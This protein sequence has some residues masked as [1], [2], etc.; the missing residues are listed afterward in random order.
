MNRFCITN[1]MIYHC[2]SQKINELPCITY[3]DKSMGRTQ[4]YIIHS[5]YQ[6]LVTSGKEVLAINRSGNTHIVL[7]LRKQGALIGLILYTSESL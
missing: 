2:N 7:P 1:L 4:Q 6:E 5:I 3:G